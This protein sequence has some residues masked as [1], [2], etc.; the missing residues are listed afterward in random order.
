M[1]I[2]TII[3]ILGCYINFISQYLFDGHTPFHS[4]AAL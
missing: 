4:Y 1:D 2:N 3:A